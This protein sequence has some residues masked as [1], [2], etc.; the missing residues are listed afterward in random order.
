MTG[1]NLV[2]VFIYSFSHGGHTAC[3]A[4]SMH[5]QCA[6]PTEQ[7]TP[8]GACVRDIQARGRRPASAVRASPQQLAV[9]QTRNKDQTL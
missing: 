6:L 3:R 2:K 1:L 4:L 9:Q 7:T 8:G 5:V